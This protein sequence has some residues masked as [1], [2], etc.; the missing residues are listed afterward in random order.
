MY[1]TVKASRCWSNL[2]LKDV[3]TDHQIMKAHGG[4]SETDHQDDVSGCL[5]YFGKP[6]EQGDDKP[7][8]Q[9]RDTT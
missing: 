4:S 2:V 8:Q 6:D 5:P 7:I 1:L 3:C 9:D